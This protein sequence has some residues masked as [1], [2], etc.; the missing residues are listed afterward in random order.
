M[1]KI[2]AILITAGIALFGIAPT[3]AHADGSDAVVTVEVQV[4]G[5]VQ[6][7]STKDLSNVH[8]AT[9]VDGE[10]QIVKFDDLDDKV[11]VFDVDGNLI[12]V[13]AHS[14]NNTTV[15]A[16]ALL[17]SLGGTVTG[18]STGVVA[19]FDQDALD[20][21]KPEETTTTTVPEETTT[22][23]QPEVT[24]TTVPE[25]TTT[26]QPTVVVT[27]PATDTPAPVVEAPV[28]PAPVAPAADDHLAETGFGWGILAVIGA[29]LGL[30]GLLLLLLGE[31]AKRRVVS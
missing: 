6:V 22:T 25:V 21:C 16:E 28:A 10:V 23:T 12:A 8:I 27:P 17:E 1:N 31:L 2:G 11:E 24:T 26:T 3:A 5:D 4:D 20:S 7:T 9:C 30:A 19:F 29:G 18:N 13:L 14:G 15:E